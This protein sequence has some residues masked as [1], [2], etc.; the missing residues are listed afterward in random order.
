M[1]A[2]ENRLRKTKEIQAVLTKGKGFRE[3]G[4]FLKT[5]SFPGETARFSIIVSKKVAKQ[6]VRRNRIRRVLGEAIRQEL[7]HVKSGTDIALVVLP[8]FEVTDYQDVQKKIHTLL[9]KASLIIK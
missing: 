2:K 9:Q 8:G 7:D 5:G 6:A 1:L 4:L 3:N